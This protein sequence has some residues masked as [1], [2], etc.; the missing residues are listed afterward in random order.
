MKGAGIP[1]PV[2]LFLSRDLNNLGD[3]WVLLSAEHRRDLEG[4]P[5]PG[6][7]WPTTTLSEALLLKISTK[8]TYT[9][10]IPLNH[11]CETYIKLVTLDYTFELLFRT[12]VTLSLEIFFFYIY[13][14]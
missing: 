3:T 10:Q 9:K 14:L 13:L 5:G 6:S 4:A 1:G 11:I 12:K 8:K 2:P 7:N